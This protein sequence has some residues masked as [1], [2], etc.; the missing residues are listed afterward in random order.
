MASKD[1]DKERIEDEEEET[2][3]APAKK[4][5]VLKWVLISVGLVVL[6][7]VSVGTSIFFMRGMMHGG[8]TAQAEATAD[9]PAKE[10]ETKSKSKGPPKTA[11]YYKLDPP[12]VVNFQG[13]NG[14]RFLQVTIELMTYDPDVVPAIEQHMPVIRNNLVFLL[15]SVNYDQISTLEGKQKLRSDTL[16]EIQ[17]ILKEKIGKPGVEEVYFTSIVMQ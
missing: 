17:R 2:T 16:A 1:K 10:K 4:K 11:V 7:G 12:F 13:Q 8:D 3:P 14:S 6:V 15:S 9:Q 5:G